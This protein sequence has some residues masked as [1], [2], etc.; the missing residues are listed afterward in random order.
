MAQ[1][2]PVQ[3]LGVQ[4]LPAPRKRL[5]PALVHAV[6]V[7]NKHAMPLQHAPVEGEGHRH[8]ATHAELRAADAVERHLLG[9]PHVRRDREAQPHEVARV[10]REG[11]QRGVLGGALALRELLSLR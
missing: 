6:S 2:A 3:S 5:P 10:V 8:L 9:E 7:R 1:H 4:V 11:A